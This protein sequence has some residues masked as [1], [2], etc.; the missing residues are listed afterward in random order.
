MPDAKSRTG[1]VPLARTPSDEE[2][3]LLGGGQGRVVAFGAQAGGQAVRGGARKSGALAEFGQ[4][5][6]GI[7]NRVQYPHGFVENAD[8]AILSH[9]EILT[10]RM[11][12]LPA[13][14]NSGCGGIEK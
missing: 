3:V 4:T 14:V 13:H 7:G 12:R 2:L 1:H 10:S 5:A 6:R 11:L 8:A 9:R